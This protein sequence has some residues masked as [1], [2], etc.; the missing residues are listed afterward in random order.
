M[1]RAGGGSRGGGGRSGGGSFSRSGGSFSRSSGSFSRSS[2]SGSSFG[3]SGSGNRRSSSSSFGGG[4]GG[5]FGGSH[6]GG[7]YHRPP[8]PIFMGPG[9]GRK[10]VIINN[11]GNTTYNGTNTNTNTSTGTNGSNTYNTGSTAQTYT[12]PKEL[13]PEQKISRAERLAAE[14]REARKNTVGKVLISIIL[15]VVGLF[16]AMKSNND[17]F[18]KADLKGTV[19]VGYAYDDGFTFNGG[20]TEQACR[21][22]YKA[23]GI[24]LYFYTVGEY[25]K[26]VNTCDI[27]T[28]QLYD[29]LFDDENHVMI[30]YYNNVDWWSWQYGANASYYMGESE[31]NELIDEIYR[32]WDDSS[33]SNDAVLAKGIESYQ[34][35]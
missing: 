19:D 20:R 17:V 6:F 1:G 13:T 10:T 34:E 27:Y 30:A 24:P 23:T 26:D 12:A 35:K 31:I 5:S 22:F 29:V 25:D 32:Y 14:A 8:R 9:H 18:E 21:A 15:L 4:F 16:L 28:A 2:S 7:S 3:R 11:S 33:L